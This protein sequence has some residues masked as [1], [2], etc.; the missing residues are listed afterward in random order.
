MMMV[1]MSNHLA[2]A[3]C[4][5]IQTKRNAINFIDIKLFNPRSSQSGGG[6]LKMITFEN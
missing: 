2:V 6:I 5:S 4:I 3:G 1:V